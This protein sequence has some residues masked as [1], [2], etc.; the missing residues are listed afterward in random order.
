MSSV[1]IG[2]GLKWIDSNTF[3]Y[4]E[5]LST[6]VI[7][8]G[9][10]RIG[11]YAFYYC[12]ALTSVTIGENVTELNNHAFYHCNAI[13]EFYCNAVMP[14][15]INTGYEATF[16]SAAYEATL[17]VPIRCSSKYSSSDWGK[18]FKSIKEFD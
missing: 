6:V 18:Y 13:K 14:P 16:A 8:N 17:Y 3:A 7:G 11:D 15:A 4:C 10:V 2:N 1:V 9:V 5:S 12:R